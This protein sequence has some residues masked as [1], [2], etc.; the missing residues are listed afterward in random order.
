MKQSSQTQF[1]IFPGQK[2]ITTTKYY[3]VYAL[4]IVHD[5]FQVLDSR[6]KSNRKIKYHTYHSKWN[7]I[8]CT[9][10]IVYCVCARRYCCLLGKELL[11]LENAFSTA[12]SL[13]MPAFNAIHPDVCSLPRLTSQ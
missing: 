11:S 3:A 2:Y 7:E 13:E 4:E 8:L 9:L 5:L 1:D 12:H 10:H 6:P